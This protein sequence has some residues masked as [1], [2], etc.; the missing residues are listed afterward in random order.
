MPEEKK[1]SAKSE[2]HKSDMPDKIDLPKKSQ[3]AKVWM[4]VAIV[5]IIALIGLGIYSYMTMQKLNKQIK[6]QQA[7]ID[8]LNNKKKT[9]EDAAA[10][11][12]SA[13]AK[14]AVN[15]AVN[16]VTS[17]ETDKNQILA[18]SNSYCT[19]AEKVT[20]CDPTIKKQLAQ[21]AD[22]QIKDNTHLLATKSSNGSWSIILASPGN[23]C[24]VGVDG[25]AVA[26]LNALCGR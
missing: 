8:D 1:K 11:A 21:S 7:Q 3:A 6:D 4:I 18:S 14:T 13:A 9:L 20:E 17:Q 25:P 12:A 10:A 5:A 24:S 26:A 23:L 22:I 15:T 19:G 16:A 2:L